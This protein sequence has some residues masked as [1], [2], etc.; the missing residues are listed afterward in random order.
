MGDSEREQQFEPPLDALPESW[1]D[2]DE[3]ASGAWQDIVE[4]EFDD[5]ESDWDLLDEDSGEDY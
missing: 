4:N 1:D 2:W 5:P 3:G